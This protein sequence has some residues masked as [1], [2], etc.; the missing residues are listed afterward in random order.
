VAL[1]TGAGQGIG[2]ALV[3]KLASEGSRVL[4]NDLDA[5]CLERLRADRRRA[6][7]DLRGL[8]PGDVTE[9]E[10]GDHAVAAGA[11]SASTT[12]T[13]SSTMRG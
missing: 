1:V 4:A 8:F 3:L 10:F 9:K 13:S 6:R 5:G 12:S 11:S 7:R 2:R